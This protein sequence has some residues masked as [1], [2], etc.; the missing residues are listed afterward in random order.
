MHKGGGLHD[1]RFWNRD[2]FR[3]LMYH[4]FPSYPGMQK[5]LAK[6]FDHINRYYHAVTMTDIARHLTDGSPLPKNALAVTIDDGGRDFLLSAYPVFKAY[7]IPS[8]VYLVSGFLDKKLWLWWDQIELMINESRLTSFHLPLIP[9]A[10]P[11]PFVIGTSEER[12]QAIEFIKEAMKKLREAER[13]SILNKL[14]KLLDVE[15]PK[16][17]PPHMEPLDWSE[18]RYLSQNGVEIGAHTVTHP[19]LSRITDPV[20]LL[21]EIGDSKKRIE[22]ELQQPVKHFCYPYGRW[23]LFDEKTVKAVEQCQFD[24]AVTAEWGFNV[25][26]VHPLK[27]RRLAMEPK[28]PEHYFHEALAGAHPAKNR[29]NPLP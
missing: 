8:T 14:P 24:T 5:A 15:L 11:T 29:E 1:V 4:D 16:N 28:T 2:A 22:E 25:Q 23:G 27:L 12:E 17:P 10:S 7:K 20:E 13:I 26:G 18:V 6:Q 19:I 3:I 9:G 21:V